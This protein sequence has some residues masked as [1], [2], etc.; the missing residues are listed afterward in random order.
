MFD[1]AVCRIVVCKIIKMPSK[2]W[3][4]FTKTPNGPKCN[5]CNNAVVGKG[6]NTTN[7][8]THLRR[9]HGIE[10]MSRTL[11]C[12]AVA[13]ASTSGTAGRY[14]TCTSGISNYLFNVLTFTYNSGV[15][16]IL[17]WGGAQKRRGLI[18]FVTFFGD[19]VCHIFRRFCLLHFREF[20][21]GHATV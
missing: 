3:N 6:G 9:K 20:R 2:V 5:I 11:T 1:Q 13:P 4:Y 18:L 12:T 19:F 16:R 14:Y 17:E 7:L 15:C 21:G 10:V 8:A